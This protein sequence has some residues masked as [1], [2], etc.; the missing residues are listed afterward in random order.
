MTDDLP[1]DAGRA[2]SRHEAFDAVDGGYR[3]TTTAF[4]GIVTAEPGPEYESA[5]EVTVRV[6]TLE[7][8]TADH[9]GDAVADGWFETLE[10]RLGDAPQATRADLALDDLA[11]ERGDAEVTITFRYTWGNADRAAT[12]AKTLVEYVEGTYVE[13]VVPGYAYVS[14]VADL[15]QNA[16]QGDGGAG[17]TPL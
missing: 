16:S 7:A 8:A 14:P 13:G 10:R 11:V 12:I 15:L 2:L 6:P 1:D 4:D 5:Y 17:G 3:V 9:V